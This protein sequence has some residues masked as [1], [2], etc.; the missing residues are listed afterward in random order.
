MAGSWNAGAESL[1]YPKA[2]DAA[3]PPRFPPV[4]AHNSIFSL[5]PALPPPSQQVRSTSD[6]TKGDPS[7]AMGPIADRTIFDQL[8]LEHLSAALRFA[9][10]LTGDPDEAEE[11]VQDALAGAARG[12][13]SYAGRGGATF[14][15]WLF[16]VVVNA[17]RDRLERAGRRQDV[18]AGGVG[19]SGDAV[20]GAGHHPLTEQLPDPRA[21]D[22]SAAA[23][24]G[25][26]GEMTARLVSA[27]PPR[28]REVLVLCAYENL[29]AP[30]AAAVLGISHQNVRT[31]LHLA[32]ERL[33]QQL[34]PYLGE[35]RS[36][37]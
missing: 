23:Q 2:L 20:R 14:R 13:K 29:S 34:A 7:T 6:I 26:L 30:E 12:W 3:R 21:L 32:R 9:V 31:C 27:L 22:P 15:T 37:R 28:Q 17:F 1:P 10:R 24:A 35:I 25:E 16:Q 11:V 33:R 19:R 4:T 18:A 36:E 8:V 5:T